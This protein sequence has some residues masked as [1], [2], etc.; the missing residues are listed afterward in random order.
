MT[1]ETTDGLIDTRACAELLG[2]A[3]GTLQ[4]WRALKRADQPPFLKVG[5]RAVRYSPVEVRRWIAGRHRHPA[6]AESQGTT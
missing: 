4:I 6:R 5:S 3:P 1:T 2:I